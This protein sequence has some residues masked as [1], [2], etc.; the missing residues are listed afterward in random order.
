[1]SLASIALL[2]AQTAAAEAPATPPAPPPSCQGASYEAFDFW[3]GEWDVFPNAEGTPDKVADSRI[4]KVSAG[5]AIR[6]TWM[7]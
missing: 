6:E 4:E 3:V 5:C 7:P 2:I 1:M